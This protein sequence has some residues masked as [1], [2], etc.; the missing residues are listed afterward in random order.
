MS[1]IENFNLFGERHDLPDVVH[2]ETIEA[3]SL[4]HDWEFS[5]HRH[6]HL[7]QFLLLDSGKGQVL[8]E[9]NRHQ[10]TAG[11]LINIPMG[12][13]HGFSFERGTQGWVVT[14]ASELLEENLSDSEGLR[15]F[16]KKPDVVKFSREIGVTVTSIFA[17]YPGSSRPTI[18]NLQAVQSK[19]W[20][21]LE[22]WKEQ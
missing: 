18:R 10:I 21:L 2:C 5:P 12:T 9:E 11:D 17:E 20:R 6:S 14:V 16:L 1:A 19:P 8:I 3:R 13:V 15:P 7:H 4:V 22:I